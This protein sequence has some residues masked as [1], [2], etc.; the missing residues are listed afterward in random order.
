MPIRTCVT[1]KTEIGCWAL[2]PCASSRSSCPS[3]SKSVTVP[4][5][6]N[7]RGAFIAL[8]YITTSL[9]CLSDSCVSVNLMQTEEQRSH[10]FTSGSNVW[11]IKQRKTWCPKSSVVS[12][13]RADLFLAPVALQHLPRSAPGLKDLHQLSLTPCEQK[14]KILKHLKLK[15]N[16]N[17]GY[18]T[19]DSCLNLLY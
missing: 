12:L 15:I 1:L 5:V 11:R 8:T 4:P 16:N 2:S 18:E 3:P 6:Q 19:A 13:L 17:L 14:H 9:W 10:T 7:R